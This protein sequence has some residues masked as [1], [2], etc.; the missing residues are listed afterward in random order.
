MI[1]TIPRL[2]LLF[3]IFL[4]FSMKLLSLIAVRKWVS[5]N[6][7]CKRNGGFSSYFTYRM[8]LKLPCLRLLFSIFRQFSAELLPLPSENGFNS[9]F[10]DR[11]DGF[12]SSLAHIMI[13]TLW[14]CY[15]TFSFRCQRSKCPF[16]DVSKWFPLNILEYLLV[17]YLE[18]F[19]RIFRQ[20]FREINALNCN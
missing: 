11:V 20:I 3:S 6:I 16:F 2:G 4:Q 17:Y 14:D 5:L 9:I 1:L 10:F 12:W 15:L 7:Y 19:L 8:I 18:L 13:L